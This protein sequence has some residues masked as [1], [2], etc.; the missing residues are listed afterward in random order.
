[1]A[2]PV[3]DAVVLGG[4]VAGHHLVRAL[5]ASPWSRGRTIVLVDDRGADQSGLRWAYWSPGPEP[6]A[7]RSWDRLAVH[8]AGRHV[9]APLRRHRYWQVRGEDLRA[10]CRHVW[11]GRVDVV[12]ARAVAVHD[13]PAGPAVVETGAGEIAARW[14]FDGVLA[15]PP[16]PRLTLS[17]SGL[18]VEGAD[19]GDPRTATLID[20]RV[21][22]HDGFGFGYVL[23]LT[24]TRALV[25]V[26]RMA[27]TPPRHLD[28]DLAAFSA[29]RLP[30]AVATVVTERA[31]LPL[32]PPPRRRRTSRRVLVVGTP[33][34]L[35][36]ASTGYGW[37]AMRRDAARIAVS[38]QRWG[39][40]FAVAALP[41]HHRWADAVLADLLA[42]DPATVSAAFAALFA[43][44]D[45]DT[46]LD[47]LDGATTLQ[48]ERAL[49]AVLPRAAFLSAAA[50]HAASRVCGVPSVRRPRHTTPAPAG[51][52]R[53]G[54]SGGA[55]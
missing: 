48:Q 21:P 15:V 23:P 44:D 26:V 42:A 8:A 6:D 11:E 4:G 55:P 49:L 46:V 27:T 52:T 16:A 3:A 9:T 39:H 36:R 54:R 13:P 32:G 38:L 40:P 1:M 19:P 31:G 14:V 53:P 25:E 35:V 24:G 33:A 43:G 20:D 10:A 47:F 28:D 41:R 18:E 22:R 51:V 2:R 12:S 34:G 5:L 50:R 17:F 29:E 7:W 45:V 37:T 30:G